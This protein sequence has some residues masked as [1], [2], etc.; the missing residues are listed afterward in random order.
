M[1]RVGQGFDAHRLVAERPLVIGGVTLP[2]EQG[3]MAHSDGDV[4]LHAITDA[5]LGALG[6]G[7]IGQHFPD[8]D[9]AWK[10]AD[11]RLLLKEVVGLMH[12]EGW[13]IGN[14]DATIIAQ[15]P[16]MLGYLPAMSANLSADLQCPPTQLNL[17]ATTTEWMGFTGRGEGIAALAMVL[18]AAVD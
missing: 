8:S 14:L 6:Q 2:F 16:K 18:L 7:D 4:L 17:K 1:V 9:S 15:Q 5:I 11:S 10:D 12:A 3:L 13:C